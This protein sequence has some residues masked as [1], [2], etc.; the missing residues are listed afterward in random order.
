MSSV[1]GIFRRNQKRIL[2]S[3]QNTIAKFVSES[4]F[5]L[6]LRSYFQD[7]SASYLKSI[8]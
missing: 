3:T 5:P 6:K 8:F 4:N 2:L 1:N 7:N